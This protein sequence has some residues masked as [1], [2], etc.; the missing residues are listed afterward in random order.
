V[1]PLPGITPRRKYYQFTA[2]DDCARL[3]VLRIY[4]AC[5]RKTAT[6]FT[7]TSK[8]PRIRTSTLSRP[9]VRLTQARAGISFWVIHLSTAAKAGGL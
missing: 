3:R 1:H 5:N 4:P 6:V 7:T 2:I 8:E 9:A